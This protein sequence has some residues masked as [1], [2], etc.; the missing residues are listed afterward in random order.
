MLLELSVF[1][2]QAATA[3]GAGIPLTQGLRLAASGCRDPRLKQAAEDVER[4]VRGGGALGPALAAHPEVFRDLDAAIVAA[5][6]EH[7]RL[8]GSLLRLAERYE[9]EHGD[10][11]RVLLALLYPAVLFVAALF[12]PHL[13][14]WVT[15]SFGA[16]LLAVARTVLPF[17]AILAALAGAVALF[18]R[19][20]PV[21]FDRARLSVPV[22]GPNLGKMAFARFAD[23]LA[24]LYAAGVEIRKSAR[25][26][27]ATL[28]NRHLEER[29]RRVVGTLE[30]GG[31]LG[32]GLAAAGVFPRE[33]VHAVEVGEKSG[34]LDRAL[35]AVARLQRE[36]ADRA[37]R[38]ILILL[39][40]VVFLLVAL[41]VAVVV[42][43][44]FGT[45]FRLVGG[46]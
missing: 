40:V 31:G 23:T 42:I 21:A 24:T 9:R 30:R 32:D 29:C 45:Y 27:V 17:L 26:A 38:A 33:L 8:D 37:I 16:W 13:H 39:P 15:N 1:Y 5:G 12:L 44:S 20:A 6:E 41:Y 25:L 2:R 36:E 4:R 10:R 34:D 18:R 19:R 14:V 46:G 43:S 35:A 11:Q 22:L 7:G 3:L 28:G